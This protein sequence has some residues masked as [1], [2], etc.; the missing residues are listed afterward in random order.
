[1]IRQTI[2]QKGS[3]P[4]IESHWV[5]SINLPRM[6]MFRSN[7]ATSRPSNETCRRIAQVLS[8]RI[9]SRATQNYNTM[10]F[11][12]QQTVGWVELGKKTTTSGETS[13]I[14]WLT[15]ILFPSLRLIF[16]HVNRMI[17]TKASMSQSKTL[18]LI[19]LQSGQHRA[20]ARDRMYTRYK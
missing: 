20:V 2:H 18:L 11:R 10:P 19:A 6:W 7:S 9:Q 1:M 8:F 3:F 13:S 4:R 15:L 16:S 17:G 5:K 12:L 14:S